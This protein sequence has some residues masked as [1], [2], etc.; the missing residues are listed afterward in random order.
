MSIIFFF[1]VLKGDTAAVQ[2][3]SHFQLFV[4]LLSAAWQV[5]L[6][7]TISRNLLKLMFTELVMPS[8]HLIL[9]CLLLLLPSIFPSITVFSNELALHTRWPNYEASASVLPMNI[10]GWFLL[11]LTAL[12]SLLSKGLSRIFSSITVGSHLRAQLSLYFLWEA[13]TRPLSPA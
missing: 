13:L 10:Q 5:S 7:F 1:I 12:I 4:T 6:P 2:S 9:Y 11:G 3:L 8:N